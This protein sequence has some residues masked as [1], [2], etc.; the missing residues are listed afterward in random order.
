MENVTVDKK[1]YKV[2]EDNLIKIKVFLDK[3]EK[4]NKKDDSNN[5]CR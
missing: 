2:K 4:I 3:I 1:D 5:K